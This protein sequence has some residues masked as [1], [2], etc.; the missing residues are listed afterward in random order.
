MIGTKFKGHNCFHMKLQ[1]ATQEYRPP[2]PP[3][4]PAPF[5]QLME[6]CWQ[7]KPK[8][9]PT[10]PQVTVAVP[11]N[12]PP[13]IYVRVRPRLVQHTTH[14]RHRQIHC[15]TYIRCLHIHHA[16]KL[17][18]CLAPFWRDWYFIAEQPALAP[19]LAHPEGC[20]AVRVAL[21]TVPRVCR[22][23]EQSAGG[24]D[25]HLLRPFWKLV[26]KCWQSP[27]KERFN[28]PQVLRHQFAPGLV[29][30]HPCLDTRLFVPGR[31]FAVDF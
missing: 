9:R 10:F 22:S 16:T 17:E 7:P 31:K 18:G 28:F 27:P 20:A 23:C 6:E 30:S 19:H 25:I 24:F 2:A 13:T 12:S 15:T 29:I 11:Q 14:I 4:C 8:K 1:V 3:N 5:W 26:E 21:V